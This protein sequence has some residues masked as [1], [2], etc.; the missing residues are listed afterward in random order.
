MVQS[1]IKVTDNSNSMEIIRHLTIA[2]FY[3][4]GYYFHKLP[5]G[6]KETRSEVLMRNFLK[7]VQAFHKQERKVEFYADRLCLSPKYLS[8]T[9]KVIV[10]KPQENGSMNM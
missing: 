4:L 1:A 7:Q 9:I 5:D 8:Q 6:T 10:E 2:F 3:G